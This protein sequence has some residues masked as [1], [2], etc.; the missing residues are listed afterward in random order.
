M[1]GAVNRRHSAAFHLVKAPVE[2]LPRVGQFVNVADYRIFN[3]V[4]ARASALPRK[5]SIPAASAAFS[6][7]PLVSLSQPFAL[8]VTTVWP[9]SARQDPVAFR[10]QR[11]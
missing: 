10:G 3:Q 1:R 9:A 8:A 11:E 5:R 2:H 7:A 4:V 6:K